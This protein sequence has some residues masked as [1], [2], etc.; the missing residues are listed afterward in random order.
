MSSFRVL[1]VDDHE[2]TRRGIRTLLSF[3]PDWEICGEACNGID[4]VEKAKALRPDVVLMDISMPRMNGLDAT[5]IIRREVP[6]S[7]VVIVSQ[8]EPSIVGQQAQEVNACAYIGKMELPRELISTLDRIV[9]KRNPEEARNLEDRAA[10]P[11]EI[12]APLDITERE[13]IER[14]SG[15][16]AAIVNSSDD[17][18]ISKNLNGIITSWNRGAERV[19][20]YL[21]EEAVGK[22][23]TLIIPADRQSEETTILER[24]KRGEMVDHFETV[25]I[26]KDG[27]LIDISLT[28][29]PVRDGSGR[30][31][32][33]SKVARDVSS[34]KRIEA[35]LRESEERF[36]AIVETTPECVKLVAFDGTLLHMN[37]SGLAMVGADCMEMV[38]GK[39]VYEMISK[40]DRDRFRSFNERVCGGEKG[41]L[42]FD[43]LGLHG[44]PR[45]VETHAAPLRLRDG[46]VV[47]LAVTR[48]ITE[49]TRAEDQLRKSEEKLRTL[50]EELENQVRGRTHEL[51]QRN[52]EILQQSEQLQDLSKRL[53]QAQDQERRHIAR[54]LHDSAGQIV[55]VLAMNLARILQSAKQSPTLVAMDVEDCQEMVK[56]LS[57]EIRTTSYLLYPP[58]L[59]ETGLNQALNWYIQGL[60]QRSDLEIELFVSE[61]FGRLP[62]DMEL[63]VYRL[64]QECLTNIH[65]H[66]GS[67][68]ATIRLL[69]KQE[70]LTVEIHDTGRGIQSDKLDQM[71]RQSAGVG[72]RGMRERVR[73]FDGQM[74]I[75]SSKDGTTVSFLFQLPAAS[76]VQSESMDR[77]IQTPN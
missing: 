6:E 49:R 68:T 62:R 22:H 41:A 59:D 12:N 4:A 77:E 60:S 40:K 7:E 23:I 51:Q 42:E 69:R 38:V 3:R 26:R 63:V 54:E 36:R 27:T 76:A 35:A 57:K 31:V 20:G 11:I 55:T 24:L 29:S 10:T 9:R 48:D 25:R 46:R 47:Q 34:R 19:F 32:G 5:R 73:Q 44:T 17:A 71:Q 65:R 58:L 8:N 2:A 53:L 67:K 16:L 66:S 75:K 45:R 50:A 72:I 64:V 52:A 30:V 28:I 61:D 18:I 56:Q 15:L 37:S 43:I 74:T 13:Q 33:A 14:T 39:S 1:I 21:A 70:M